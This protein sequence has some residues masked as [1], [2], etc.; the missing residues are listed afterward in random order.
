[1]V[2][3]GKVY[4]ITPYLDFHPGGRKTLMAAAGERTHVDETVLTVLVVRLERTLKPVSFQPT[5]GR[6]AP[7]CSTNSTSG[8]TPSSSWKSALWA[9]WS[10]NRWG[11]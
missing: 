10:L 3:R 9:S 5:Q 11:A 1:M 8:S 4:N 2:L 7:S 6:T